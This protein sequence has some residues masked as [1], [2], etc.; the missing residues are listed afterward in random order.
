MKFYLILSVLLLFSA[1]HNNA[2]IRTQRPLQPNEKVISVSTVLPLGGASGNTK[3]YYEGQRN[4]A[5]IDLGVI[6][7][8]IIISGLKGSDQ[9]EIGF[10]GGLG[11]TQTPRIKK[12]IGLVLGAQK[13]NYVS[14]FGS[15]P[16][17]LGAILELNILSEDGPTIHIFPS[18][19]TTTNKKQPH[20]FGAHGIIVS[21]INKISLATYGVYDLEN[22]GYYIEFIEEP[23][24]YNSNSLGVGLTIGTEKIFNKKSSF[25]LQMDFSIV[26]NSFTNKFQ[27]KEKWNS[28]D[29]SWRYRNGDLTLVQN[30]ETYFLNEIKDGYRFIVSGS[31]GYNFFNPPPQNNHP[32][33][34]FPPLQK[35]IFNP[36]TGEKL[37]KDTDFFDPETGE[38]ITPL[39]ETSYFEKDKFT[40][41]QLVDL[42]KKNAREKHIGALWSVFGLT[43]VPSSAFGSVLGLVAFAEASDGTLVF[44]GFIIGGMFGAILPSTLAKVSSR[45]ANVIYPPE[46]ETKEQKTKY[47]DL[48]RSEV[49]LLRQKST[50]V[51]TFGGFIAL[52]GFIML[53]VVGN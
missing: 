2:H 53:V 32:I 8:R 17:K 24:K 41:R 15:T 28:I 14:F 38:I 12:P 43:G 44:P 30:E 34:P 50:A 19:T 49:G 21:G 16:K 36:E 39:N 26:N 22:E 46:I 20:Y 42:A 13:K 5:L 40:E 35:N 18:I 27:P 47:K 1:C 4:E 37:K 48:Y 45:L 10:Y 51:G 6:A 25:Q 33:S 52:T 9:S 23:F 31:M 3:F 29:Y 7:P 11:L